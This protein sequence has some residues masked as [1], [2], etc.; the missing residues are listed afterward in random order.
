MFHKLLLL[1]S[2]LSQLRA[3]RYEVQTTTSTGFCCSPSYFF[4]TILFTE[5][6]LENSHLQSEELFRIDRPV[7]VVLD[8]LVKLHEV[9]F[10]YDVVGVEVQDVVE[11][12]LEF[13]LLEVRQQIL[14][15]DQGL[16]L[17]DV[18]TVAAVYEGAPDM[19]RPS[20]WF[21]LTSNV[22]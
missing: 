4:I 2:Q 19:F 1:S 9:F 17:S 12:I 22:L 15:I 18:V 10:R 14:A 3:H 16:L 13:V 8:P 11:E 21:F 7:H 6:S 20:A 5:Y